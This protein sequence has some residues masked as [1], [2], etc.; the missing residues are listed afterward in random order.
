[1]NFSRFGERVEISMEN[2]S[3]GRKFM[4]VGVITVWNG[5]SFRFFLR[6]L[7]VRVCKG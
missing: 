2:I 1:M 7:L 3:M 6:V 5:F 4:V